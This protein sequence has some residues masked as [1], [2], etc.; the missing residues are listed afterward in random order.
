PPSGSRLMRVAVT[1]AAGYV[2]GRLLE[3][4]TALDADVVALVGRR[5]PWLGTAQVEIDVRGAP[6]ALA[7]AL[8]GCDTVV[9]LAG[10]NEV[11]AARDPDDALVAT[12]GAARRVAEAGSQARV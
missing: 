1:G 4:L 6:P 10:P 11:V 5:R 9:H 8:D 3:T 2:G 7:A 12:A